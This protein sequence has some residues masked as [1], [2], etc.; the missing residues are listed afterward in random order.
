MKTKTTSDAANDLD[1]AVKELGDSIKE[2][3][4]AK[5]LIDIA[6]KALTEFEQFKHESK[7]LYW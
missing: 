7:N 6:K 1:K 4:L 2:T 3:W 5:K